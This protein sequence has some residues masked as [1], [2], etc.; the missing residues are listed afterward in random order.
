V[1]LLYWLDRI[2][3]SDRPL[4]GEKAFVLSQ[5]HQKGYPIVPGFTIPNQIFQEFF[6]NLNDSESILADFPHTSLY[7]DIQDANALQVVARES[8]RAILQSTLP[9]QWIAA[10]V[11][12]VESLRSKALIWRFSL[13]ATIARRSAGLLTSPVSRTDAAAIEKALKTAWAELFTARSLFYWRKMGIGLEKVR[14]ALL[15]Q[16]LVNASRSGNVMVEGD[17]LRIEATW[18]LG[19]SLLAGE[20]AP[21]VYTLDRSNHELLDRQPGNKSRGY[22]LNDSEHPIAPRLL[23]HSEQTN[24]CLDAGA[25]DRLAALTRSLQLEKPSL[26]SW[27]WSI[28]GDSRVYLLDCH[29]E[30][31]VSSPLVYPRF[32]LRGTPASPGIV[33]GVVRVL[34]DPDSS[35]D[36]ADSILVTSSFPPHRLP[37]LKHLRGII[38]EH[39]GMTSHGAILARELGIPA[40]VGVTGVT[41]FLKSGEMIRLDG[42]KGMVSRPEK[43]PELRES[44]P[45]TPIDPDP[46]GTRLMVNISQI[47]SIDRALSLPVDGIGLLRSEWMIGDLL[48][49]RPLGEWIGSEYKS[50]FIEELIRLLSDFI[51]AFAPRPVFYRSFDGGIE[52]DGSDRRGTL[53]YT[54]DPTLFDLE[55][56]A[57]RRVQKTTGGNLHLILPFVRGVG[58]FIGCRDRAIA[59]GLTQVPSF[60]LW[61]MGEVPSVL[62]QLPEYVRAGVQGIAIGTNDLTRLLL[63]IDRERPPV[64]SGL[65]S[66]HPALGLA[67]E[68]IVRTARELGIPCS[69]C[70]MAIVENPALIDDLVRWGVTTLSVDPEAVLSTR[71]AIVRAEKRLLL[72]MARENGG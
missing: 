38:T 10:L 58:E 64:A 21:D 5:L 15:V 67:L 56:A 66:R 45:M 47:E 19:Q 31:T 52:Q 43:V 48:S 30:E 22:Y 68:Q 14:L 33:S 50:Q 72:E 37:H 35:R 13:P 26:L 57:L 20:V 2:S 59:A 23:D 42:T 55:L 39:G 63:G 28:D 71:E 65:D 54:L 1:T 53:A 27:N 24:D 61:M 70:G 69:V 62:F 25:L 3:S 6:E 34:T 12:A 8:R 36:I 46:V 49:T 16:P 11:E 7:L 41:R 4:V 9:P 60:Q 32:P 18:G 51:T 40:V 17:R 29:D 44:L